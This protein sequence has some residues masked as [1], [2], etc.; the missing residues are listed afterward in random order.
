VETLKIYLFVTLY[1]YF[2]IIYK[3]LSL[4][5]NNQMS[6][7]HSSTQST[8][9]SKKFDPLEIVSLDVDGGCMESY[10][11]QHHVQII[12]ANGSKKQSSI[13]GYDVVTNRYWNH[14]SDANKAH[15]AYMKKIVSELKDKSDYQ[16]FLS[17]IEQQ[18]NS[19]NVRKI[20][21]VKMSGSCMQSY[22]CQHDMDIEYDDKTVEKGDRLCGWSAV[23]NQYWNHLSDPMKCH[24]AYM[25]K[26][27]ENEERKEDYSDFLKYC[28]TPAKSVQVQVKPV[29]VQ[30]K[31]VQVQ[32]KPIQVDPSDKIMV[33]QVNNTCYE[34]YP[35]KHDSTITYENG[36]VKAGSINGWSAVSN[37]YW[38]YLTY[39]GKM[40]IAYM[41][42][43]VSE[44]SDKSDYSNFI[45]DKFI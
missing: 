29:Q 19:K 14:L 26:L 20:V 45:N 42:K 12:Y 18:A 1:I 15:F 22:P 17:E 35:C 41:K 9:K 43:L 3:H 44:Q 7:Q 10:P 13:S 34:S 23:S 8:V 39:S 37:K 25:I 31:P 6:E 28:E 36:T 4:N 40:H 2:D 16:D 21:S 27:I 24:F 11:C 32:A 30:A 33:I 38:N 5:M